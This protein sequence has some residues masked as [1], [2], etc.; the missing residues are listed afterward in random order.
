MHGG[1][2]AVGVHLGDVGSEEHVDALGLGDRGV[3]GGIA[4]VAG[5]VLGRPELGRVHEQAD[6]D[7]V[8]VGT[9]RARISDRCPSWK[10]PIVGTKPTRRP[11]GAS[12]IARGADLGDRS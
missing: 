10:Y 2:R 12:G 11:D 6:D 9:A 8:V 5:E 7:E 4:R 1:A 3:A